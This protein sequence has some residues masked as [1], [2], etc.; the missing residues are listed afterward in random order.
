MTEPF[1]HQGETFDQLN[2]LF[3]KMVKSASG[4]GLNQ[5]KRKEEKPA[6][7]SGDLETQPVAT[8]ATTGN[9]Y[10]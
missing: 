4:N 2:S 9:Q 10:F 7:P 6:Q 8:V 5:K 1:T 3:I